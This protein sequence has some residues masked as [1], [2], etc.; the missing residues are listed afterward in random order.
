MAM[1][2]NPFSPFALLGR[3]TLGRFFLFRK[4]LVTLWQGFRHPATPLHVKALMLLV[5][6][7]L[8]SPID[9]I[10]DVLPFAGWLDD[11]VIVPMLVSWIVRLLPLEVTARPAPQSRARGSVIEGTSRRL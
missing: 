6:L 8:I 11:L 4:E 7:Y 9:L 5:P 1:M 2:K 3:F 10:P